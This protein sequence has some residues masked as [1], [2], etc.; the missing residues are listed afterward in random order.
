M[1]KETIPN[2]LL[3]LITEEEI[4]MFEELQK[5]IQDLNHK[6]NL[7]RL[8]EGEDYWISQVY[9]SIWP[10]KENSNINFDNK[11]FID[12][13]SG[14]GFP[15]FAYAIIHPNSEIYLVDSSKKKTDSLKTIINNVNFK[16][17]F[18]IINERIET[19]TRKSLFKNTFEIAVVRAVSNPS[20]VS[21]YI[22]P[23]LIPKGVGILYCGK[24]NT[25]EQKKLSK[26]LDILNG[27]ILEIKTNSLPNNRGTRNAIFIQPKGICPLTYPRDVGK[28]EKYPILG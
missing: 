21:E 19:F 23:T 2:K 3:K 26:T 1:I 8:I 4:M 24:W 17:K 13:G 22:L 16:N 25:E 5:I 28:A 12:I 6:T 18:F 15:G 20:T 10:F 14:C 27:K 11:K 9:D 7:T